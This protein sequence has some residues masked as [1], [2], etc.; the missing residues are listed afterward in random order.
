M[1]LCG[2]DRSTDTQQAVLKGEEAIEANATLLITD[3]EGQRVTTPD[4]RLLQA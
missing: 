2:V 1:L 3:A 4:P